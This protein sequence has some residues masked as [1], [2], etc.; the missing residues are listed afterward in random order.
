MSGHRFGVLAGLAL[1]AAQ[2]CCAPPIEAKPSSCPLKYNGGC[3]MRHQ[4]NNSCS[5]TAPQRS[6]AV[7]PKPVAT[8]A[9]L[10]QTTRQ[11]TLLAEVYLFAV[12]APAIDRIPTDLILRI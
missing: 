6:T 1:I 7:K 11:I 10:Q 4:S 12:A 8:G 2:I 9:T 3:P 5:A